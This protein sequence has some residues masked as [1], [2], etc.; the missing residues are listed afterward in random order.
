[1]R[2]QSAV[3]RSNLMRNAIIRCVFAYIPIALGVRARDA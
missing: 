1:V 2:A 3:R